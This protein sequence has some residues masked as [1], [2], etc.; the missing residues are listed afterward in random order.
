MKRAER[1]LGYRICATSQHDTVSVG[2][3]ERH[4]A[5]PVIGADAPQAARRSILSLD[6]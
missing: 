5:Q 1:A 2:G 3:F 4:D 6:L